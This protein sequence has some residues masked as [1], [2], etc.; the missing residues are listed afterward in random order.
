[1]HT[2]VRDTYV[3]VA[4]PFAAAPVKEKITII[5]RDNIRTLKPHS[6]ESIKRQQQLVPKPRRVRQPYNE[7]L[8]VNTSNKAKPKILNLAEFEKVRSISTFL[9]KEE[10]EKRNTEINNA[11]FNAVEEARLRKEKME[12]HDH[13]R[14]ANA[15]LNE[16]EQE[17][18]Q[19]ANY[20]LAKAKMQLEEQEDDIKHL[21]ELMLY[22]KCVA[23]RDVQVEEK[24]MIM[25]ERKEEEA[26]LDAMME[27]KRV[28]ELKKL[29]DR[30]KCRI[31]ELRK[32]ASKIRTQIEERREA[33]LLEQERRDQE[34][35]QILQTI[36]NMNEQDKKDKQAKIEKSK[37]LMQ[38]VAKA[39]Q[40]STERKRLNKV[41]EEEIDKKVLKYILDKESRE[42]END[43]LLAVKKA[44]RE[45]ELARLRAA[46]EK[47][48]DKQTQQDLLRAKRA[49]ESYER[50][51][52]KKEK[53]SI[54]KEI[55]LSKELKEERLKQQ[56]S[57]E[58]AVAF[59]AHKLKLEFFENI[60]KQKK[61]E[62][63]I[64]E[65]ERIKAEKNKIY[66]K[67]VKAQIAEKEANKRK[68]REEFF[69]E[70]IRLAKER[71]EKLLKIEQTKQRKIQ[72]LKSLGVPQKYCSEIEKKSHDK[73]RLT[74]TMTQKKD[75]VN[76]K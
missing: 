55:R 38:E 52:R 14:S 22:A 39:N 20:L 17:A 16:L 11:K 59:E 19:K 64:K 50:E 62:E 63:K 2:K 54:E 75:K 35:K 31:E 29:E 44:E 26:R 27:G 5:T 46:Q 56:H 58:N 47:I 71:K 70:G 21:N 1:M 61:V 7:Q 36:A 9:S 51:W 73:E 37:L 25:Q 13:K 41:K 42:I 43:R 69:M 28:A 49:F 67:E 15:K 10:L 6:E 32:G 4:A 76:A 18:K 12:E 33:A 34:T 40:E 72:E 24:K 53:E 66:A 8:P 45:K 68:E 57:R 30:E 3:S 48:S 65:E 23:I 74:V 60:E